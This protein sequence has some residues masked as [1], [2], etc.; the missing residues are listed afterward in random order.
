MKAL[1]AST[2][3]LSFRPTICERTRRRASTTRSNGN[4]DSVT[5]L[6]KERNDGSPIAIVDA[7]SNLRF[8]NVFNPYSDVCPHHDL[9]DAPRIR[10][11]NLLAT[12]EAASEGVDELWIALEPGHKGARRTGLAMT[13]DERL[14]NHAARWDVTVQRATRSGP[15]REQT[16]GIVWQ[17]L[18]R[19]D[20]RILLWNVFPLHC[21]KP[22]VVLSNRRHTSRERNACAELTMRVVRMC[23]PDRIVAIGNEAQVAMAPSFPRS[24]AVR[25]PAYGGKADFLAGVQRL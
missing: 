6:L 12:F 2:T 17:A 5:S 8:D 13:D 3:A 18:E 4:D 22:E 11:S 7:L 20:R 9:P 15:E 21:H 10:R 1:L 25:H 19:S 14:Q 24:I 23:R 16:A